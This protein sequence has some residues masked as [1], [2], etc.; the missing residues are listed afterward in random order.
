MNITIFGGTGQVGRRLV[1]E[2]TRRG[3]R[4]TAVTRSGP[5][6]DGIDS[7]TWITGDARDRQDVRRLSLGRDIVISATSGPRAGGD[8]LAITARALL[9]G[10][11]DTD[12]RLIVVGGAGP[13][14][15][16]V[17][18]GTPRRRRP[19]LRPRIDPRG[20]TGLRR[21]A[22]SA[23]PGLD[24]RLDLLQPVG[25]DDRRPANGTVHDRHRRADRRR[26]RHLED[27]TRRRCRR[28][29]RRSRATPARP[30][31]S[32]RWVLAAG[33]ELR[34]SR[35]RNLGPTRVTP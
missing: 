8:E 2:A 29:P 6:S 31:R 10:I 7:V 24:G 21:P 3:H 20:R 32:D 33:A 27:L 12:A 22:R 5:P 28:G 17:Q 4:V 25:P 18:R 14:I 19:P 9:D 11:A 1:D 26:G 15:V 16:P 23:A 13:L 34:G 30:S 35:P